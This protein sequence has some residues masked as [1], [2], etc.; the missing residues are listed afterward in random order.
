MKTWAKAYHQAFQG[1]ESAV[2]SLA[3]QEQGHVPLDENL[4]RFQAW[5][6]DPQAAVNWAKEQGVP[7]HKAPQEAARFMR[8]MARKSRKDL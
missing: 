1:Q 5:R 4:A 6:R 7:E 2:R 8:E 3:G